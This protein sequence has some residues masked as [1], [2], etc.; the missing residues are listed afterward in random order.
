LNLFNIQYMYM[1]MSSCKLVS[2]WLF[3]NY[4]KP[5]STICQLYH[6]GQF[7]WWGKPEYPKKNTDL[8]Q[9]TDKLYHTML[10]GVHR[11]INGF[12]THIIRIV[13]FG[14]VGFHLEKITR[15]LS[16]FLKWLKSTNTLLTHNIKTSYIFSIILNYK[17][18]NFLW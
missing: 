11:A 18:N 6:G 13:Q 2:E 1:R 10:Y 4:V 7:C 8:S 5:L 14:I 9:A 15:L 3:F 12:R 16:Y 17:C